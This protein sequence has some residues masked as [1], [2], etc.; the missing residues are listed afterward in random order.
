MFLHT[1]KFSVTPQMVNIP[2]PPTLLFPNTSPEDIRAITSYTT[3]PMTNE[4]TQ[5]K[6]FKG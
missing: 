6:H 3:R 1:R 2:V 5:V 4:S